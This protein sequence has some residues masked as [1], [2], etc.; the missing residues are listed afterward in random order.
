MPTCTRNPAAFTIAAAITGGPFLHS[1]LV[2]SLNHELLRDI[3][4]SS[5]G[6]YRQDKSVLNRDIGRG[7]T[8]GGV[9]RV[10]YST[11]CK[12]AA[13]DTLLARISV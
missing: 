3:C 1:G 4:V 9:E 2:N 6:G 5:L 13:A 8:C 10:S 7:H 11:R 12:I